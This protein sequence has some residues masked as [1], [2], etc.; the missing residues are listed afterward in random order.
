MTKKEKGGFSMDKETLSNYGWIV[1]CVLVLAVML[2]FATPFGSFV[3]TAVKSTTQGLFD[4]N[5]SALNSTGLINIG[6]Q[7]FDTSSDPALNPDNGEEVY[8]EMVY[9]SGEYEYRYNQYYGGEYWE[10]DESQNGWGVRCNNN[11]ANPG[12]ILESINGEPVVTIQNVFYG[13][14][15]LTDAPAIP[16]TVK[17]VASAFS[18]CVLLTKSPEI[19]N[20]VTNMHSTFYGC[21]ALVNAPKIPNTVTIMDGTFY[22][23]Q[24]LANAPVL[25]ANTTEMYFIFYNCKSLTTAPAIPN[26]VTNMQG[27]FEACTSLTVA[28]A[29]P[30]TVTDMAWAFTRCESLVNAPDM[31]KA[32]NV[33]NMFGSFSG[34]INL[35]TGPRIPSSAQDITNTYSGCHNITGT[36]E[37]PCTLTASFVG[38]NAEIVYYHVDGCHGTCG[39]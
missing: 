8:N 30:S 36:V 39:K 19:P 2:A 22:N 37:V 4:V 1:I 7:S 38:F 5:Y 12:P 10:T 13:C 28:P 34:C 26:G 25:S 21:T 20:G 29:I 17:N 31:S 35:T 27:A 23:C 6:H 3:S 14:T 11:V 18:G 24:S 16:K 9:I 15:N 33:Q 32:T